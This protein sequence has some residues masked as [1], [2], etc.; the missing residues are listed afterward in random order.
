VWELVRELAG[1]IAVI[2]QGKVITEGT[3]GQL[4]AS[5]GAG[6][7]RVWL[8]HSQQRRE[9]Q[10][11]LLRALGVPVH[12]E[13]DESMLSA[14]V[15]EPDRVADALAALGRS[16]IAVTDFALGQ[17]SLDEVFLALTGRPAKNDATTKEDA[18]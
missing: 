15:S 9:A 16:G 1:R 2:D 3:P 8:R 17:P 12:L 11:L 7:L 6:A 18:A 5:V 14:R 4:E 10:R 13:S